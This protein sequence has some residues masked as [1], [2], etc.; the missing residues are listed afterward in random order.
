MKLLITGAGGFLGMHLATKLIQDGHT[1]I[2]FSRSHHEKLDA[3]GVESRQGDLS[4]FSDV[5]NAFEVTDNSDT[6]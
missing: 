1:V 5:K 2:S 6:S 4:S 3:L